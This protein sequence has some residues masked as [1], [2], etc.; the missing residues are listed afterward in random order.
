M[1]SPADL[2]PGSP[3]PEAAKRPSF[4]GRS[5]KTLGPLP[6]PWYS[7][8]M[9][10]LRHRRL[11]APVS[12][13]VA[14]LFFAVQAFACCYAPGRMVR[15]QAAR[16]IVSSPEH[17]CCAK[18][19]APA[20]SPASPAAPEKRGCGQGCCIQ[21]AAKHAPQLASAPVEA[22]AL[23]ASFVRPAPLPVFPLPSR[24]LPATA[25]DS[26]PPLYLRTL[27]LLV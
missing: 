21:D 20:E 17:A 26:G 5:G 10:G 14:V 27:R 2:R 13:L 1:K 7:W 4:H 8:G 23:A 24:N 6:S 3:A 16:S 19:A 18:R 15:A 9:R 11:L 22:P 12:L 25:S